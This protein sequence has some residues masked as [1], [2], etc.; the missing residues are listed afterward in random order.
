MRNGLSVWD[1]NLSYGMW[2]SFVH[3]A[4]KKMVAFSIKRGSGQVVGGYML[5]TFLI[6]WPWLVPSGTPC[7]YIVGK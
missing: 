4:M 3:A 5:A 7:S 2:L 6:G 1:D